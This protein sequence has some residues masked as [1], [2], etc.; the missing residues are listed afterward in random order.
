MSIVPVLW[1]LN[2]VT[3]KLLLVHWSPFAFLGARFLA[4]LP[5]AVAW[6]WLRGGLRGGLARI[7]P[8]DRAALLVAGFFGITLYQLCF[9]YSLEHTTVF[10]SS[11][12]ASTFPLFT[13]IAAAVLGWER[14]LPLR[15]AG[16]A[17]AFAGIVVFEGVFAGKA[18]FAGGDLL[19]LAGSVLFTPYTLAM[20]RLG[21]RYSV[22]ELVAL[23][24]GIGTVGL[25]AIGAGALAQQD[26]G[27]LGGRDWLLFAYV[28]VFPILVAYA[29]LNWGIA[30]IGA[31][32]ASMYAIGVPVVGGIANAVAFGGG[33]PLYQLAGALVSIAGLVLVQTAGTGRAV[34]AR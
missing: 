2:F 15:W 11:L 7:A 31:G 13:M 24:I 8:R 32:P 14:P 20:R 17:V 4:I 10:A 19:A 23:T 22:S 28:V 1:G 21:G 26:Y 16:A 34:T 9:V 30:R 33:V 27:A 3:T 5:L 6:A 29:I 12:L 25:V 18:T